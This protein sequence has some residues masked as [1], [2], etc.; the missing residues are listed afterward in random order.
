MVPLEDVGENFVVNLSGSQFQA[1]Q[2]S[3]NFFKKVSV[4]GHFSTRNLLKN[5][6]YLSKKT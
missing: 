3:M 5:A 1:Q 4:L 2:V 6:V